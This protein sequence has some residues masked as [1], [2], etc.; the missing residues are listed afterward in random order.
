MQPLVDVCNV[1]AGE[2]DRS[3][4]TA[5]Y[6]EVTQNH[7]TV[8]PP[9]ELQQH[10]RDSLEFTGVGSWSK[11]GEACQTYFFALGRVV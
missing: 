2:R 3:G 11:V 4:W 7:L 1:L 5:L 10:L 9:C 6:D 8:M